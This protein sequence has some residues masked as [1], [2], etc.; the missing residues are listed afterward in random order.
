MTAGGA[1][2]TLSGL[3]LWPRESGILSFPGLFTT[4]TGFATAVG[5]VPL[6]RSRTI[7]GCRQ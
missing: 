5:V 3:S 2:I 4:I 7:D 6:A 1:V